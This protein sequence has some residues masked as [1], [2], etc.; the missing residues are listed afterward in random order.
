[1][2]SVRCTRALTSRLATPGI[3]FTLSLKLRHWINI[4]LVIS[5]SLSAKGEIPESNM[6]WLRHQIKAKD[7][8]HKHVNFVIL[9]L[10]FSAVLLKFRSESSLWLLLD[11]WAPPSFHLATSLSTRLWRLPGSL[12]PSGEL[13][14]WSWITFPF[15]SLF[16]SQMFV[17]SC[18][19]L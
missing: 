18:L 8:F 7:G 9:T 17:S 15:F 2:L 14:P 4:L 19:L 6:F 11:R 13:K 5:R 16:S 10:Y 3:F 12:T 1:M